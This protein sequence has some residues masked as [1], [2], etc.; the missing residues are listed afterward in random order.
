[1]DCKFMAIPMESNLKRLRESTSDSD[2]VDPMM[3]IQLIGSLIYLVNTR[4]DICY[5]VGIFSQF[6]SEPSQVHWVVGKQE[7][8]YFRGTIEH[9]LRYASCDVMR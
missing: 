6:M 9:G 5:V 8:W 3:Y 7:L 4:P 1:M 2:L